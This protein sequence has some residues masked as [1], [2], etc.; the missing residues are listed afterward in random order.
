MRDIQV[1][2]KEMADNNKVFRDLLKAHADKVI[3]PQLT[4]M[5]DKIAEWM[6][7]V[8]DGNFA[9]LEGKGNSGFPVY[10]GQLHDST[11]I[12][13]YV[14]GRLQGYKP[15]AVGRSKQHFGGTK[16][17]V[18]AEYLDNA[19]SMASTKFAK[20]IWIVLFSTVPYAYKVN[21]SGSPWGRGVGFFNKLEDTIKAEVFANIT[22]VTS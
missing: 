15:T 4:T 13:V 9:P 21:T 17:I 2:V 1:R 6:V 5:L 16:D 11:G 3:V 12:G 19:I 14:N 8:I 20:G 18:G 7:G 22:A 10:S